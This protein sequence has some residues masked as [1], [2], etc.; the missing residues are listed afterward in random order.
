MKILVIIPIR[1]L[2]KEDIEERM[3]FLRSIARPGTEVD[4]IQV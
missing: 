3:A 2:R 1:G 4:Y